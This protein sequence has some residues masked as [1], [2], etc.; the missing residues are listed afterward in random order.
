MSVKFVSVDTL[1]VTVSE[2]MSGSQLSSQLDEVPGVHIVSTEMVDVLCI[3]L[4]VLKK[5]GGGPRVV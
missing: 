1:D 5:G 2:V 4:K 3:S